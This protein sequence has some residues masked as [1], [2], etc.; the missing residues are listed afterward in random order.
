MPCSYCGKCKHTI[1]T[2][3]KKTLGLPFSKNEFKKW[4][5]PYFIKKEK[6]QTLMKLLV[7]L[8]K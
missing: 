7:N 8:Q 2:C 6:K 5:R 1:K 3:Q 4:I